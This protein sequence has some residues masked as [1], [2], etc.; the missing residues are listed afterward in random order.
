M[1]SERVDGGSG[2]HVQTE[3]SGNDLV[4]IHGWGMHG[5]VWGPIIDDLA[6]DFRLS[7]VDLPGH[8]RSSALP[9]PPFTLA[10][11]ARALISHVP[12]QA[13]W[14]GWS[15]GGMVAMQAALDYP[16][17]VQGLILVA[18]TPRFVRAADWPDAMDPQVLH[19]FASDLER[20]WQGTLNRFLVL[21]TLGAAGAREVFDQLREELFAHGQP[22]PTALA[23]GLDILAR[24]DLRASVGDVG[25]PMLFVHGG[26][27]RVVP[28]AAA[29][30]AAHLARDAR[31]HLMRSAGH[32]P[33]LSHS[34]DFLS[35]VR[36][37][38]NELGESAP[39][40]EGS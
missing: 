36:A 26:R 5:G 23:S 33:F 1:R 35:A 15:L 8:G 28:A 12:D 13:V 16:N 27:D 6:R 17:A 10:G 31:L 40:S 19:G 18:T 32:A 11:L 4:L 14:M 3:G 21:E 9:D 7:M 39:A 34:A 24:V 29:K 25:C 2:L 38:L 20:D 37:F 22:D 30:A